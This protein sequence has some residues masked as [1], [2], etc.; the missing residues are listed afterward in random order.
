MGFFIC[1][2][3][4]NKLNKNS[5]F[6]ATCPI[7]ALALL[8]GIVVAHITFTIAAH[9]TSLSWSISLS[10]FVSMFS[11]YV[12]YFSLCVMVFLSLGMYALPL[13]A[14][15]CYLFV[16]VPLSLSLSLC[17]LYP[18]LCVRPLCAHVIS[19]SVRT[20]FLS[21]SLHSSFIFC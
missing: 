20:L 8:S 16:C 17:V 5:R 12:H 4:T 13:S 21:R 6:C 1:A 11:W 9:I 3:C 14:C 2:I 19:L 15:V 18:S 7:R 10:L